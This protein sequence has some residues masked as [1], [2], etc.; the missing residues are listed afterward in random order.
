M[1]QPALP[2]K[3]ATRKEDILQWLQWQI[4]QLFK[5][6]VILVQKLLYFPFQ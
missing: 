6:Q 3:P 4:V 2:Q 1:R 5:T